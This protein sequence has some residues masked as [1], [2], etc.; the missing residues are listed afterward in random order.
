[1]VSEA[2]TTVGYITQVARLWAQ[3]SYVEM[4]YTVGPVDVFAPR[5]VSQ[6]VVVR[7]GVQGMPTNG[8]W[9]SDSNCREALLRRRDARVNWTVDLSEPV[10]GNYYPTP[11]QA[12]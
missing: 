8:Q 5:D 11:C 10:A 4:E 7:Y 9:Y 6:E 12:S 3:D 2:H 1:M